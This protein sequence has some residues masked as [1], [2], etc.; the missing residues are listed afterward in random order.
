MKNIFMMIVVTTLTGCT[1]LHGVTNSK[2]SGV[3]QTYKQPYERVWD[4]SL[5]VVNESEL[6]MVNFDKNKGRIIAES[7]VSGFS[8]G[9]KV[10]VFV[11]K[12]N[13][14]TTKVEVVSKRALKT[15]ITAKNWS[16]EILH[17]I[18]ELLENI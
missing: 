3:S 11:A 8:W 6:A 15:N 4:A 9:E 10:A 17:R 5:R 2:G 14:S 13:N 7:G 1:T 18:R 12:E 16:Y